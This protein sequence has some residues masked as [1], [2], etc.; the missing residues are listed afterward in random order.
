[1]LST[2]K[3]ADINIIKIK[4]KNEIIKKSSVIKNF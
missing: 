1:M 4:T 3:A 2:R